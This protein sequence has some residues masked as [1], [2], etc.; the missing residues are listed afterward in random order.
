[1]RRSA[2]QPVRR[3]GTNERTRRTRVPAAASA[4]RPRPNARYARFATDEDL[5]PDARL[6]PFDNSAIVE[7]A[8][9]EVKPHP[10]HADLCGQ[11]IVGMIRHAPADLEWLMHSYPSK[12]DQQ[13]L[14]GVIEGL[15]KARKAIASLSPGWRKKLFVVQFPHPKAD[16]RAARFLD[17]IEWVA[18]RAS[19]FARSDRTVNIP[20]HETFRRGK[21]TKKL[22]ANF[23][24]DVLE[25]FS[26]R[27]PTLTPSGPFFN[28]AQILYEAMTGE[29]ANLERQCRAVHRARSR[30]NRR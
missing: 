14:I 11:E 30:R 20:W 21:P 4:E 1:M 26:D 17:Y 10:T 16:K 22:A 2:R 23:A 18:G 7:R 19:F 6:P 25:R 5:P 12:K 8:L 9:L 29:D 3:P 15:K 13:A 28:L 24:Y 27:P